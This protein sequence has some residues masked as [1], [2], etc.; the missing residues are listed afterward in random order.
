[1]Q[2]S[3]NTIFQKAWQ[4]CQKYGLS[5]ISSNGGTGKTTFF[6]FRLLRDAL[7][8]GIHFHVIVRYANQMDKMAE[9]ILSIMPTYSK[10]QVKI[11][12]Q[13]SIER[14][15]DKFIYIIE[16]ATKRRIAQIVNIYGQA[17][18]KPFGNQIG[19]QRAIIDEWLAENGD[20]C[21]DEVNRFNRLIHTMARSN[22]YQVIGLYNNTNPNFKY[23]KYYK[24]V[25][26]STHVTKTG[27]LFYFFTAQ[28]FTTET[29]KS[30]YAGSIQAVMK[31]TDYDS[32][33]RLNTFAL[34]PSFF[35][36]TDLHGSDY[37]F[38]LEIQDK[39]FKVRFKDGYIFLDSKNANKQKRTKKTYSVNRPETTKIRQLP[40]VYRNIINIAISKSA[41]KTNKLTDTIFCKILCDFT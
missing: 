8:K 4:K 27:T 10:R 15:G 28:Q 6:M 33:Y 16:T 17:F 39:I 38:K 25:S 23:F 14:D 24:G 2:S 19:A 3:N 9:R 21:P 5:G 22:K 29:T 34:Y 1:M 41:L 12:K 11:L 32:V 36:D 7:H 13:L 31:Q 37:M 30:D 18:Y 20:Y 40:E 35:M 26:Y